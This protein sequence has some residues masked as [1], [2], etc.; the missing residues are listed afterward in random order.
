[1]ALNI[2]GKTQGPIPLFQL[3]SACFSW[4]ELT[5]A[6][7]CEKQFSVLWKEDVNVAEPDAWLQCPETCS[8]RS[9]LGW[10]A[11]RAEGGICQPHLVAG[12]D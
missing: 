11:H 9:R 2:Y 5:S 8:A 10:G 12:R 3:G 4:I 6:S 1:M 7:Q